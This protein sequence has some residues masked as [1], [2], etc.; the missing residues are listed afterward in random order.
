M[1]QIENILTNDG[2]TLAV[3]LDGPVGAP[4]LTFTH[5]LATTSAMWAPQVAAFSDRFRIVRIDFRGHGGS[6]IA[7]AP[8]GFDRLAA[9]VVAVWDALGITRSHYVGLSLGGIVGAALGLNHGDRLDR[10]VLADCR[11]DA[12]P[13]YLELWSKRRAQV[14]AGGTAA[15]AAEVLTTWLTPGTRATN[16]QLAA[17]LCAGIEATQDDGWRNTVAMFPA[18]DYKRRLGQIAAPTL[19][20]CGSE[21]PVFQEMRDCAGRVPNARFEF[22]AGAAHLANLD[23]PQTFDQLLGQFLE[24]GTV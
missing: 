14:D 12:V 20:L 24:E 11:F 2:A 15:I 13:G 19:F 6:S 3:H 17:E 8:G 7:P 5:S 10:L 1:T 21:D 16:P 23:Q 4:A 9:D 22:V 18:L